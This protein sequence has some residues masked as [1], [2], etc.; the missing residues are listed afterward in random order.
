MD[1]KKFFLRTSKTI[2]LS[3]ALLIGVVLIIAAIGKIFFPIESL[4]TFERFVGVFEILF[5]LA[6][7]F[8]RN[9]WK[10][11]LAAIVIFGAWGG[12]ALFWVNVRL[13]CNCMGAMVPVPTY[14]SLVLDLLFYVG[15][16]AVG[17]LLGAKK[18]NVY[19]S[20]ICSLFAGLVGFALGDF[21]WAQLFKV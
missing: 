3:S 17:A 7:F 10:T 6:I 5:F 16:L 18:T 19:L 11:W 8:F 12:Y 4:K 13:P 20:L 2:A 1:G 15:C 21:L 14:L 9:K